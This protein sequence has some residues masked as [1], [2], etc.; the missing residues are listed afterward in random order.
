MGPLPIVRDELLSG[1]RDM[2]AQRGEE[3]EPA[4]GDS[5][6]RIRAGAAITTLGSRPFG[7][8]Y[9]APRCLWLDSH[10]KPVQA[11]AW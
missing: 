9:A 6:R 1:V 8:G 7:C 10:L 3:I 4:T 11:A 2:S 5:A